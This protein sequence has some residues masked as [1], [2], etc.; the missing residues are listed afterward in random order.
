MVKDLDTRHVIFDVLLDYC[1]R[2]RGEFREEFVGMTKRRISYLVCLIWLVTA[3]SLLTINH[4]A[5]FNGTQDLAQSKLSSHS[6]ALTPEV[7]SLQS[8]SED[9]PVEQVRKNIQ[10]LKGL[11]SSQLFPLMNFVSASLGVRCAYCHVNHGGGGDDWV[12]ES[13]DKETKRTA[14]QM[15]RMV[16]EMNRNNLEAFRGSGVTC[17]TCHRGQTSVARLP[18]LPLAVSGH[19]E[20]PARDAKVAEA[21]PSADEVLSRYV[22]AVGGRAAIA[23]LKTRVMRGTREASQGR[24][25]PMEI[26]VKEPDKY[27]MVIQVPQQGEIRQAFDGTTAWVK[28]S[29]GVRA[30]SVNEMAAVKQNIE[31]SRAIKIGEPFPRMTVTGKEKVGAMEAYVLEY[32][33][34]NGVTEKLFFDVQTGLLLRKLTTKETVLL[35]IPEQIDFEDYRIVDGVK[36]PFIIRISNIDTYFSLTRK[37]TEIKHNV[38]VE[39]A[40]FNMPQAR[41]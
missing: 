22:E 2:G 40:Q 34:A 33:P 17:F 6:N 31:L 24:S 32:R 8:A 1:A 11:P 21:L 20:G 9:K 30:L 29:Q 25:W 5:G 3:L 35:P 13:D 14:R 37:L 12:W 26:T 10:V 27:L 16:L 18:S 19:E 4:A 41:P 28:G 7:V 39:D 36:L 15:M 23:K 38:A